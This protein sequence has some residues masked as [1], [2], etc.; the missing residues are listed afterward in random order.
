MHQKERKALEELNELESIL[1]EFVHEAFVKKIEHK[2]ADRL[3]F[4]G[5][6][7]EY[8]KLKTAYYK[9]KEVNAERK[10]KKSEERYDS[11]SC[12]EVF[13]PNHKYDSRV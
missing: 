10:Y 3:R 4:Y 8:N 6:L 12:S 9:M 1:K 2:V 5:F 11:F 13:N 7:K